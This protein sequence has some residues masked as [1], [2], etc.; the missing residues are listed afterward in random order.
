M[1]A[2][3]QISSFSYFGCFSICSCISIFSL[4]WTDSIHPPASFPLSLSL[5]HFDKIFVRSNC[6]GHPQSILYLHL[7][8]IY[9]LLSHLS[10]VSLPFISSSSSSPLHVHLFL[11]PASFSF[12]NICDLL[13]LLNIVYQCLK[14]PLILILNYSFLA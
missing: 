6:F 8:L 14:Y 4:Y 12:P 9:K 1:H 5:F 11:P 7:Q 13:K 2:A 10:P 3:S